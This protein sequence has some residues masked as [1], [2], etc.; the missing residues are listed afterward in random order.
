MCFV[1]EKEIALQKYAVII[2]WVD[3][4]KYIGRLSNQPI[5]STG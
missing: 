5:Y 3:K 4:R 1:H 2:Q